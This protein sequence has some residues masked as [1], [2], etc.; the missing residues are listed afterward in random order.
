MTSLN[1][2]LNFD[3][4]TEEAMK[5]YAEALGGKLEIMKFGDSPMPS[6]PETK[7]RVMHATLKS[8][9]L[10]LM[11][12]DTMPGQPATPGANVHLSLNF[13][14]LKEQDR[15]WGKLS[16]GGKVSMPLKEEFFGRFGA[17]TDR[18]GVNWMLHAET[19]QSKAMQQQA[20]K[21]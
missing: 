10:N 13:T 18:F 15:V 21:K 6:T 4:K 5:F 2:Y 3:G 12:S 9:G 8:E 17:L 20:P 19:E 14:D 11:A 1:P 16:N 7:N